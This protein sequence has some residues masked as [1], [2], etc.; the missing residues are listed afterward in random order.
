MATIL[1][2]I[3]MTYIGGGGL[4]TAQALMLM[5]DAFIGW[6]QFSVTNRREIQEFLDIPA[7][8]NVKAGIENNPF[9]RDNGGDD[10]DDFERHY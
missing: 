8:S 2:G 3:G 1:A 10:E 4:V 5:F 9:R 7:L 6:R